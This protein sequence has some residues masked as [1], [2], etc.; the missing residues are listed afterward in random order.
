MLA[1]IFHEFGGPEVLRLE[2]LPM[3][4][5]GPGEVVVRVAAST[6]NPTD[7]LMRSGEQAGLMT[8]LSPPYVAGME[9]S[10]HVEAVGEG[11]GLAPGTPVIGVVNPRRPRGGAHAQFIAVP[12]AS[13]APIGAHVDIVAAATIPMNGL[14][15]WLALDLVGL[16]PGEVLLVT[17]GTGLLGGAVLQLARTRGLTVAAFG[18]ESDRAL[19]ESLGADVVIPRG[20]DMAAAVFALHPDGVDALIDGALIGAQVSS[21]VRAGGSAISLRRS[22]PIEDARLNI[23]YVAVT[24]GME[25]NAI[26]TGLARLADTGKLISREAPQGRFSLARAAEAHRMTEAGGFRGRV[27]LTMEG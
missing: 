22:H 18:R 27:I 21:A 4:L 1:S 6:I 13:V 5:A 9:F 8:D 25:D 16:A 10:G 7:L 3:P 14:T 26:L 20:G 2:D 12:A 17:G 11:V 24:D 15:A 19:L 23:G